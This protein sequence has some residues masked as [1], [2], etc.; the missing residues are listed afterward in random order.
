MQAVK[1]T[2]GDNF[3]QKLYPLTRDG[4]ESF[5]EKVHEFKSK[6]GSIDLLPRSVLMHINECLGEAILREKKAVDEEVVN[7][8]GEFSQ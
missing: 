1:K 6:N 8:V 7:A 4:L 5:K 3:D 2:Y